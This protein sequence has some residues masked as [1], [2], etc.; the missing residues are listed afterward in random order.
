[1]KE[2]KVYELIDG[3]D[4][5]VYIGYT[6]G[7]LKL[8]LTGHTRV[9]RGKWYGREDISIRL[10]RIYPT[11]LEAL[12]AEGARKLE[13]GMEWTERTLY[14]KNGRKAVASGQLAAIRTPEHQSKAGKAGG[15]VIANRIHICPHCGKEGK[16]NGMFRWHFDKC[17]K[18]AVKLRLLE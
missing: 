1:M 16:S 13:L 5:I 6:G 4:T 11:K 18:H 12:D 17:K 2:Y 14:S 8:R 15:I 9:K 7:P 3:T 10:Y